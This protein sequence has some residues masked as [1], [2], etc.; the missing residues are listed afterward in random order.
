M[1]S[2]KGDKLPGSV[3]AEAR[4]TPQAS[5]LTSGWTGV[6][7]DTPAATGGAALP[8]LLPTPTACCCKGRRLRFNCP[9]SITLLPRMQP[10][11]CSANT[12]AS[13]TCPSP[14]FRA[15][16]LQAGVSWLWLASESFGA[17]EPSASHRVRAAR[18]AKT[19]APTT[20]LLRVV[21]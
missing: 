17:T 7:A 2:R 5:A 6:L 1:E 16:R 3:R 18:N 11:N 21:V 8:A 20:C 4:T 13:H 9:L 14:S 10:P 12:D 19:L 15:P